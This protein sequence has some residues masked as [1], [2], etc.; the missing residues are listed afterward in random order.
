MMRKRTITYNRNYKT[1]LPKYTLTAKM[2]VNMHVNGKF[3]K[4]HLVD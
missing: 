2:D 1:N 3:I 4:P